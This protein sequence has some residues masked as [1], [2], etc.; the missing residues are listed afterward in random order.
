[1]SGKAESRNQ[2][3]EIRSQKTEGSGEKDAIHNSLFEIYRRP[4]F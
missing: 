1:M 3:S 2:K 4:V